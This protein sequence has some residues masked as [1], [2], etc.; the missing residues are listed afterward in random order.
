MG[1]VSGKVSWL[2]TVVAIAFGE[3]VCRC[4]SSLIMTSLSISPG[5]AEV[6]GDLDIVV[7]PRGIGGVVLATTYIGVIGSSIILS[8]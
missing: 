2:V 6:H 5:V 7:R 1:A 8:V 4:D 3:R